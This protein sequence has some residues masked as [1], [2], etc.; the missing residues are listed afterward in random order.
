MLRIT[1]HAD[2]GTGKVVLTLEGGIAAEWVAALEH[3]CRDW[4][5]RGQ[6][7]VLDMADVTFIDRKGVHLLRSLANLG[8]TISACP[9]LIRDLLN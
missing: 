8:V 3:V 7:V 2:A 4:L 9:A 1:D 6:S 5:T